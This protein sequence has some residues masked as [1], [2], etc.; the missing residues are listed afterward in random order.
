LFNIYYRFNKREGDFETLLDYNNYLNDVEDITFNLIHD[1]D[2]DA[3]NKKFEAYKRANRLEIEDNAQRAKAEALSRKKQFADSEKSLRE[4]R[5]AAQRE[6]QLEREARLKERQSIIDKLAQSDGDAAHVI[7]KRAQTKR[8]IPDRL[9]NKVDSSNEG[10]AV[11]QGLKK[12]P[13]PVIEAPF[14][15]FDGYAIEYDYFDLQDNY[16]TPNDYIFTRD[17]TFKAG[18][19]SMQEYYHRTM[20]GA[21]SGLS[22]LSQEELEDREKGS[23]LVPVKDNADTPMVDV[24]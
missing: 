10:V 19:Y 17:P 2:V 9:K 23:R 5:L 21:F 6:D 8:N 7:L 24:F 1:I 13:E 16:K 18:G 22:V 11:I 3:T 12:R 14:D 20:L 15:P 4:K